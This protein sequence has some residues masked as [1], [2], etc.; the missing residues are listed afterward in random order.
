[1]PSK[2]LEAKEPSRSNGSGDVTKSMAF[3]V[4]DHLRFKLPDP[5]AG[6]QTAT[7][8][9]IAANTRPLVSSVD[10]QARILQLDEERQALLNKQAT[11]RGS[12]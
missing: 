10:I 7:G 3:K 4:P 2:K 12:T 11:M 8:K 6:F 5:L 1:M 9:T